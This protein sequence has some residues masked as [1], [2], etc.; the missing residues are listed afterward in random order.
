MVGR[1]LLF[2]EH[3]EAFL[4]RQLEPI[5]AGDAVAGPVVEV[6]V[7]DDR[8][9]A[10]EVAVGGAFGSAS[11]YAALKMLSP[12]FSIAPKLKSRTATRLNTSRSYS[13]W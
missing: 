12:L 11:T 8:L 4:Q 7:P 5:A 2:A 6:L 13:R 1:E 9:D 10:L 3:G